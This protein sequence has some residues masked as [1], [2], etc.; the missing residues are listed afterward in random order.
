MHYLLVEGYKD[1]AEALARSTQIR[2]AVE[3][4]SIQARM[5][6]RQ[7]IQQGHIEEAIERI[8]E[9]DPELLDAQA[10]LYFKLQQQRLIEY[11]RQ[12]KIQEALTFAQEE[13]AQ[14]GMENP[15]LLDELERTM[16]LFAFE[17][18]SQS[19]LAHLMQDA[20]RQQ[21]ASQLNAAML[22]AQ[23]LP[24]NSKL[25]TLLHTLF[26]AQRELDA[27]AD[28]PKLS[29]P[30]QPPASTT[31]NSNNSN[32]TGSSSE[33]MDNDTPSSTA[34]SGNTPS[35]GMSNATGAAAAAGTTTQVFYF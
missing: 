32:S 12:D 33:A 10:D 24:Q 7:A 29:N 20:Q 27:R 4:D 6:I 17:D 14:R 13:L 25:P 30:L 11:L 34:P 26:W 1:A 2:P 5:E 28:Y 23:S 21:T 31:N 22:T 15:A 19:P 9:Q 16:A 8:N 18:A 3:L 35:S